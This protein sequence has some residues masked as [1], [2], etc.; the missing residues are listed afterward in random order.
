[1]TT[2]ATDIETLGGHAPT[3]WY[4]VFLGRPVQRWFDH[5]SPEWCR[6]V[7]AFGYVPALDVW[8][9]INPIE[10]RHELS[11]LP[12]ETAETWLTELYMQPVRILKVRQEE[13]H[14]LNARVGNWC[15]TTIARL[16]GIRSR[17][18]RPIGLYRDLLKAGAV[19]AFEDS[20]VDQD[21]SPQD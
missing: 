7:F 17:A 4:V 9:V 2:M 21:Q 10:A 20:D 13:G 12:D 3:V 6:H 11:I 8:V 19:P 14:W 15:T 16:V 5:M 1:M 18:W